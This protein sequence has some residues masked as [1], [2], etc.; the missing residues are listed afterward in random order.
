MKKCIAL[1]FALGVFVVN[2]MVLL[3]G[4]AVVEDYNYCRRTSDLTDAEAIAIW[5][6]TVWRKVVELKGGATYEIEVVGL[7]G[8]TSASL[9]RSVDGGNWIES[10]YA[11]AADPNDTVVLGHAH[12]KVYEWPYETKGSPVFEDTNIDSQFTIND[13]ADT[14]TI[15]L[16]GD[17]SEIKFT[18]YDNGIYLR[19][20]ELEDGTV[21]GAENHSGTGDF[22]FDVDENGNEIQ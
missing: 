3:S 4:C 19:E 6:S 1:V 20:V 7:P 10:A 16:L 5:E 15:R 22:L 14:K 13:V 12:V 2:P 18:I 9:L 17:D 21:L 11:C 8:S